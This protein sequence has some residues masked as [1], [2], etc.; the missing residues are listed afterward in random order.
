MTSYLP[1]NYDSAYF[2][3]LNTLT[4]KK[5]VIEVLVEDE[6]DIP[7]W[8]DLLDEQGGNYEFEFTPYSH[9][10]ASKGRKPILEMCDKFG[11]NLIACVDSDYDYLLNN[12]TESSQIIHASNYIFQTYVYSIEN[13]NCHAYT[14]EK[15]CVNAILQKHIDF[16]FILFLENFSTII[17]ELFVWSLY[18]EMEEL[19][20]ANKT[21]SR[22]AFNSIIRCNL[23]ILKNGETTVLNKLNEK[24][25]AALSKLKEEYPPL[26]SQVEVFKDKLTQLG[27]TNK[28]VYLFIQ[29][30]TLQNFLLAYLLKPYC[31]T[32]EKKHIDRIKEKSIEEKEKTNLVN[33]YRNHIRKVEECIGLNFEYKK[34]CSMYNNY[35]KKDLNAFFNQIS[36]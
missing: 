16:D 7:F 13:Y 27:L 25:N 35:L 1:S 6:Y 24:V 21:L 28:N 19:A 29:G 3:N 31:K 9:D 14:L 22:T 12:I 34:H 2:S 5:N 30:H 11:P 26:I 20:D 4:N 18:L 33:H 17:Y 8:N 36:N 32:C 10:T 15:V 23:N